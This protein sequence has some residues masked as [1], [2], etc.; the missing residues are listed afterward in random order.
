[1][2]FKVNETSAKLRGGYYTPFP[3]ARFL[4]RWI[5]EIE[6]QSILE[7]SCGDGIFLEALASV[8]GFK[9]TVTA[10]EIEHEEAAKA[11]RVA[12]EKHIRSS[13]L[14][15]D[16]LN[17]TLKMQKKNMMFDGILGNPPFIRYQYLDTILQLR[18][19][20]IF[21][22]H[23]LPFTKH[24]NLWVSFVLASVSLLRPGGRLGMVI[25]AEILHVLHAQSLRDFLL[26]ECKEICLI[27]PQEI[28]FENTLQG[29]MLLMLEKKNSN[30]NALGHLK[31]IPVRDTD[32]FSEEP[33]SLLKNAK[34][35]A[36]EVLI[37]KKWMVATL[38]DN[39]RGLLNSLVL[40]PEFS[41]FEEIAEVDVGIVTGAN[42]FFLVN[43]E[44]VKK[45]AL[46]KWAYPMFGR[47]QHVPGVIYDEEVHNTNATKGLP[48]NF[49][50]FKELQMSQKNKK[51]L[52]YIKEG[53]SQGLHQRYKCK[54][55]K[56]WYTVPSV[57]T[58]TIGMLKRCHDFPRLILN[59]ANAYTTD[60]AYRIKPKR[61]SKEKMVFSFLNSLTALSAEL[62]GRHYGGGVLELVPS[63]IERVIMP[64]TQFIKNVLI[65]KLD[66]NLKQR[67]S[68]QELLPLQDKRVLTQ[69]GLNNQDCN[70]LF[71]AWMKLR[72]R[73]QREPMPV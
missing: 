11:K 17:W 27:D 26:R 61:N 52:A 56:P 29:V 60:T 57:Y 18:A 24:T 5:A 58:S 66:E 70:L 51:M 20:K 7:P 54:I 73:R 50:W 19:E 35:L 1:M 39:E 37:G 16:F 67:M 62:E 38:N 10:C 9:G 49:L 53:E 4:S 14:S 28:W 42:H 41:R 64:N 48:T 8:G 36:G 23:D 33:A 6:P 45:Y 32:F 22:S 47:S 31:L 2:N 55:R 30:S 12:K 25:P 3:I 15:E 68:P 44:V 59:K 43:D 13:I 21:L 34:P 71:N 46:Q 72:S 63:E 69:L 65:E 40:Q